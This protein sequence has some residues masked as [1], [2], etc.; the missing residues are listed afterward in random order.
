[1]SN[2]FASLASQTSSTA[3]AVAKTRAAFLPALP[4]HPRYPLRNAPQQSQ[5]ASSSEA[6]ID[7][8]DI[9]NLNRNYCDDFVCTSSPAVE[10]TVR[11]LARDITRANGVWTRSLFSNQNVEY[12]GFRSFKGADNYNSLNFV[13]KYVQKPT[14]TVTKMRMLDS[15]TAIIDWR[16]QGTVGPTPIDVDMTTRI[17]MNLLTGQIEQHTDSW[18]LKRCNPAAAASFTAANLAYQVKAG[19][20]A[21][22]TTTNNILDSLTSIDEDEGQITQAD[23]NDPMK[24]FQQKDT[25]KEDALFFVGALMLFY[26]MGQA[27][28]SIFTS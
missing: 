24:F 22:V 5:A 1:M 4:L 2:A 28:F 7:Q 6:A 14:A 16:L 10:S 21:A 12:K 9:D 26:F 8:Q 18:D 27:W 25:F 23:P 3:H 15:G 13:P 11:A 17:S 19:S 20:A